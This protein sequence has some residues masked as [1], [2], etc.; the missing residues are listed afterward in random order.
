VP[1][2]LLGDWYLQTADVA[3]ILG[4][5]CTSHPTAGNCNLRLNLAPTSYSFHGTSPAGSGDVVVNNTEIDFF[6]APCGVTVGRYTWTLTPGVLSFTPL[7]D[8]PCGRSEYLASNKSFY[9]QQP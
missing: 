3:E 2:Q 1:A 9:R 7:N 8:D 4:V 5:M 6:N